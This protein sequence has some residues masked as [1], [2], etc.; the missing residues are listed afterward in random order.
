MSKPAQ[1]PAFIPSD[2][3]LFELLAIEMRSALL[4]YFDW[5]DQCYLFAEPHVQKNSVGN[6]YTYPAV[7]AGATE[8][9]N[10]FPDTHQGNFAYFDIRESDD[11]DFRHQSPRIRKRVG[12]IF[13]FDYRKVYPAAWR[14]TTIESMKQQVLNFFDARGFRNGKIDVVGFTSIVSEVYA[15]YDYW[16]A[17]KQPAMK[18]YGVLRCDFEAIYY[19]KC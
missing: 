16:E 18:P 3:Q 13:F 12:L 14:S 11:V 8:Y 19:G 9:L 15:G 17:D 5:L 7:L 6:T 4:D 10:V 1:R 2:P